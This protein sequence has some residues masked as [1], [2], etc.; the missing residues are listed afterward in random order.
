MR[1]TLQLLREKKETEGEINV[2]GEGGLQCPP[3]INVPQETVIVPLP[4]YMKSNDVH[5]K[6]VRKPI[7]TLYMSLQYIARVKRHE[8]RSHSCGSTLC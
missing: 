4:D 5:S 2:R 3:I 7:G 6:L 1:D 8:P